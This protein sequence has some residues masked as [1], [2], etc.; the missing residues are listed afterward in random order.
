MKRIYDYTRIRSH[1]WTRTI[2]KTQD[3]EWNTEKKRNTYVHSV[4]KN[5]SCAT[6]NQAMWLSITSVSHDKQ[7]IAVIFE[8][9]R[10]LVHLDIKDCEGSIRAIND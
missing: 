6:P 10:I 9:I 3:I 1:I 7:V 2:K 8:C 4:K 5:V